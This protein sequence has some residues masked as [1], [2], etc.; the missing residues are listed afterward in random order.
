MDIGFLS[1]GR[2]WLVL[3]VG[4]VFSAVMARMTWVATVRGMRGE[5]HPMP[6][7]VACVGCSWPLLGLPLLVPNFGWLGAFT[8]IG[9]TFLVMHLVSKVHQAAMLAGIKERSRKQAS[10]DGQND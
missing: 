8:C 3:C 9:V 1:D 10:E 6:G 7:A 4:L 2:F 5:S